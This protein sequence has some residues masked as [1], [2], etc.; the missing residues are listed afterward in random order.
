M[1]LIGTPES[2]ILSRHSGDSTNMPNSPS[3]SPASPNHAFEQVFIPAPRRTDGKQWAEQTHIPKYDTNSNQ[4]I[5][6]FADNCCY[7]APCQSD[8][9]HLQPGND[10]SSLDPLCSKDA[11][12]AEELDGENGEVL[13][14]VASWVTME[15]AQKLQHTSPVAAWINRVTAT[16][17]S[18]LSR[19]PPE[20]ATALLHHASTYNKAIAFLGRM[21]GNVSVIH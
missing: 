12:T 21:G 9:Y 2:P 10:G 3:L 19:P 18:P 6:N 11:F 13:N 15:L 8:L 17:N 16:L 4:Y 20:V 7:T 1:Y 5:G 14:A